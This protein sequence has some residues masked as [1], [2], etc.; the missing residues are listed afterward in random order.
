MH[1]GNK[2][3]GPFARPAG[4]CGDRGLASSLGQAGQDANEIVQPQ[5]IAVLAV[6]LLPGPPM[7]QGLAVREGRGLAEVDEPHTR[8]MAVIVYEKQGAADHLPKP[9][10]SDHGPFRGSPRPSARAARTDHRPGTWPSPSYL[11]PPKELRDLQGVPDLLQAVQIPPLD[12]V[13]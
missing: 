12:G 6:A 3:A 4:L 2:A 9:T 5:Q 1:S 10:R 7:V 11:V 13:G 8:A